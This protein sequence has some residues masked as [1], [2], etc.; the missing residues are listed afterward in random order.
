MMKEEIEEMRKFSVSVEKWFNSSFRK[1]VM[2]T[3]LVLL[4]AIQACNQTQTE[5]ANPYDYF[6]L[7]IGRYQI[8]QV[9]EM[10]YSVGQKD[11][12]VRSW[13]EKDE[14]TRKGEESSNGA[15]YIASH[16]VRTNSSDYWQKVSEYRVTSYP[17]K[18]IVNQGNEIFTSLVF[19]YTPTVNWDGYQYFNLD[20]DDYRSGYM[21]RYE[22]LDQPLTI[23]SLKFER[24][25]KVS[26]R[27]DTTGPLYFRLG[28]KQYASGIGL[29]ADQLTNIDYLQENGELVGYRTIGSGIRRT[30]KIIAYGK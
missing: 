23:D 14:I 5:P 28:Y 21:F 17:D 7:E 29:V 1:L 4:I 3:V 11:P 15:V 25:F 30:K 8:Y 13:Y 12:K 20:K 9:N 10:V 19:P 24:T 18:L 26:E 27:S 16:S 22:D 6:P 2:L